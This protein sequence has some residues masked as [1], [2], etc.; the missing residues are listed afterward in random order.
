MRVRHL[1]CI[2]TV[3]LASAA[4][5]AA[6]TAPPPSFNSIEIRS[7][8]G[9]QGNVTAAG[10]NEHGDVTGTSQYPPG[11]SN[12]SGPFV[13]YHASGVEL[14]LNGFGIGGINDFDKIA[15]EVV[16]L[17]TGP[18]AVVWSKN[19][20]EQILP[21]NNIFAEANAINDGGDIAGN[22]DNGH[23]DNFAVMW[24]PRPTLHMIPIGVLW[25]FPT[26]SD[27]ATSTAAAINGH[28]HVTG[29][30]TAGEGTDPNTAVGFGLHAYLYR[31]GKMTDLGALALSKD[32]S[33]DSEGAGINDLDQVVGISTTAI[34][35]KNSQGQ[36][37]P[38]C[39]VA[40]H[41][42]LW[43]A[44]K[45]K[46]LGNLASI[47][48]WDSKANSINDAGEIVGWSDSI[49]NGTSTHRAFL[50]VGG[51]MLNLQFSV[52]DRDPNVRL[53]EA[54]A[55]NCQGWIVANGYNVKSPDVSRVYLL[56]RRG[57]PRPQCAFSQL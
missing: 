18:E 39:G 56:I 10:L 6:A 41:A 55:I 1:G 34:P 22:I 9:P 53:T 44:G 52:F 19:G 24:S 29:S 48:G 36:A 51:H 8:V 32:G 26:E 42:F 31:S 46:D 12:P 21:S 20:G 57:A 25:S 23:A 4:G 15:G 54:V 40:S 14:A 50:Y 16:T 49:V 11:S 3:S 28:S 5:A 30:S 33:D 2:L 38:D 37:C 7:L 47:P 45:M 17:S 35:A 13:Y 27:S 43:S